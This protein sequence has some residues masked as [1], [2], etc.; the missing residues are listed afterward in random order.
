[1]RF[2]KVATIAAFLSVSAANVSA[3]DFMGL[4]LSNLATSDNA[5]SF[6]NKP[7]GL[8]LVS[9][10]ETSYL[11]LTVK[12]NE[13]RQFR[14]NEIRLSL[15]NMS[16]WTP[17]IS[18]GHSLDNRWYKTSRFAEYEH[19]AEKNV[20]L[21]TGLHYDVADGVRMDTQYQYQSAIDLGLVGDRNDVN[22]HRFRLGFT[23][24]LD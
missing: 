11:A 21:S 7:F 3:A 9:V 12:R 4:K 8:K 14:Q 6:Q 24:E 2:I 19:F 17:Y 13:A 5:I 20:S 18:A 22:D 15:P 23:W 16:A 10:S 1:M